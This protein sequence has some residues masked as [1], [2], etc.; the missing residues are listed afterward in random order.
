MRTRRA[1]APALQATLLGLFATLEPSFR[2]SAQP[3]PILRDVTQEAGLKLVT[4]CGTPQK[5]FII[6]GNGSGCA[7][8]DYDNDG[9]TDLYVVNGIS[10]AALMERREDAASAPNFLFRNRGDGTFSQ[11]T[12]KAGVAGTGLGNGVAATD[13][14]NDGWIDLFVTNYGRDLLYRNNGNGTFHEVGAT[15]G[16]AGKGEWSTGAAFGDYDGDGW[17]DLYVARYLEF[18]VDD[19][20]LGGEFC[21][22]RG[23]PVMCGPKGLKG[24]P[25]VLYR[26]NGDGTFTDVTQAAGVTDDK[27]LYGFSPVFEDFDNDGD[28]D[29]FVTNDAGPNYYFR[30]RGDGT[31]R[32]SALLAGVGYN[33]QGTAQA[34]MGVAVG[35][36]G[37]DGRVDLFTTT[38]SEEYYPFFRNL[39][40]GGFEEVSQP[41]GLATR[42]LP[43]LGWATFFLDV[44]NDGNL[45]LFVANG[46]IF[47]QVEPS[48]ET[49]RQPDLLF[50][51]NGE[52]GFQDISSRVELDQ[53][54]V[55]SSR[56]G[57]FCDYDNDGDLD[58]LVLAIDDP[59]TLLRNDG[60]NRRNWLQFRLTG[61]RGNRSAVGARVKIVAGSKTRTGRVRTG[62]SFLSQN[63]LRLHFGLGEAAAADRVEIR[64]PDG[65]GQVLTNVQANQIVHIEEVR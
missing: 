50:S 48:L 36:V 64:W 25:D 40:P 39:G 49:Y 37:G 43:Y 59:P 14:D 61:S 7:W 26:N 3:L 1:L 10:S 38:F 28:P 30:N 41:V 35:D 62:G 46:H 57:A 65:A 47:P 12:T 4:T 6:E 15:A 34:D 27:L 9:W 60:G 5:K 21:G 52:F 22:Y 11:V 8:I 55:R 54:P 53:A 33:A 44:D 20:P 29:L 16:V 31:F 2:L 18:D 23:I 42:T 58:L 13:Y 17:L 24:A 56:G 45:D 19:P 32:E 63:D 51:G